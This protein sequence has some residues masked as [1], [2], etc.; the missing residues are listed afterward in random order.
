MLYSLGRLQIR[1]TVAF[2]SLNAIMMKKLH[3]ATSQTIANALW[4]YDMVELDPPA[5]LM[6]CWARDKLGMSEVVSQGEKASQP[7]DYN[8]ESQCIDF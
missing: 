1:D 3:D 8:S 2:V 5:E 7:D 6:T 4:A